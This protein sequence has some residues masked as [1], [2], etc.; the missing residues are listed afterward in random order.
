MKISIAVNLVISFLLFVSS[1]FGWGKEGHR[2]V[3]EV[4]FQ[5]LSDEARSAV[6]D[7]RN[8]QYPTFSDSCLWADAVRKT[9][10]KYTYDYHFI[11]I[12]ESLQNVDVS[13]YCS[14]PK[15]CAPWAIRHYAKTFSDMSKSPKK[16]REAMRFLGHFV[17]DVH[18]PLHAGYPEDLGGNFIKVRYL[19]KPYKLKL[20]GIWDTTILD[21]AGMEWPYTGEELS[22]SF[23]AQSSH[24]KD[25]DTEGWT[26]ESYRIAEE[27]AYRTKKNGNKIRSNWKL[28][29]S[30]A[31][32]AL[33]IVEEQLAKA[34]F[35]L[36]HLLNAAVASDLPADW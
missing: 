9:T 17:G 16:R 3:C 32:R 1:A 2:I 36:A 19:N 27:Y 13:D 31:E 29:L 28:K 34:G 25:F 30:Y 23:G 22:E 18:Q 10:H 7:L 5:N 21:D 20:H 12:P 8:D 4:A 15:R 6:L 11:N 14:A 33:P 24:W 26:V 35:R